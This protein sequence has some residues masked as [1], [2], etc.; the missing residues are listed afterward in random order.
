MNPPPSARDGA[1][2]A[3]VKKAQAEKAEALEEKQL[4]I[5]KKEVATDD[6]QVLFYGHARA[7]GTFLPKTFHSGPTDQW[8]TF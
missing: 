4:E 3:E 6:A 2:K 7:C 5:A 8:E 1:A